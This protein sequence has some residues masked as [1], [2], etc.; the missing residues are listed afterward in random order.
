[1]RA[2]RRNWSQSRAVCAG[3]RAVGLAGTDPR[4]RHVAL[5]ELATESSTTYQQPDGTL[6]VE[7]FT[8]PVNFLAEGGLWTEISNDLVPADGPQRFVAENEANDFRARIPADGDTAPLRVDYEGSYVG[9]RLRELESAAPA[10]SGTTATF[11][12][13]AEADVVSYEVVSDGVKESITLDSAPSEAVAYTYDVTTSE[14]LE[15]RSSESGAIEFVDRDAAIEGADESD[16]DGVVLTIPAGQM[17]D[18]ASTL[19]NG[20]QGPAYSGEVEYNLR[21]VATDTPGDGVAQWTLTVTPDANWLSAPERQ[22]PVTVDPSI[23]TGPVG[24]CWIVDSAPADPHCGRENTHMRVGVSGDGSKYRSLLKF[25]LSGVPSNASIGD[26]AINLWM[27]GSQSTSTLG[28]AYVF[29]TPDQ[30]WGG[31]PTWNSSNQTGSWTGGDPDGDSYGTK[32]LNGTD[33]GYRTFSENVASLVQDWVQNVKPNRGLVFKQRSEDV[34]NVLWFRSSSRENRPGGTETDPDT[35][36][37]PYLSMTYTEPTDTADAGDRSFWS[38]AER[39]LTDQITAKVNVGN[40]NLL[41]SAKDFNVAGRAGQDMGLTRYYNS[42]S[43]T[44]NLAGMGPGWSSSLG[45]SVRLEYPNASNKDRVVFRGA[46]AYRAEFKLSNGIYEASGAGISA[47]LERTN[48]GN[49]FTLT[50]Y[51]RSKYV[52]DATSGQLKSMADPNGNKLTFSYGATAATNNVSR[53]MRVDDTRNRAAKFAYS[54]G[55]LTTATV[56][57]LAGSGDADDRAL[58]EWT[59]EYKVNNGQTVLASSRLSGVSSNIGSTVMSDDPNIGARTTYDYDGRQRLTRITDPRSNGNGGNVGASSDG[60]VTTF[61]YDGKR[62][63]ALTRQTDS[64]SI[65]D[66]TLGF[67]YIGDGFDDDVNPVV[68]DNTRAVCKA[69]N[70][71]PVDGIEDRDAASRTVVDGERTDV[72]DKTYYCVDSNDRVLRVTDANLNQRSQAYGPNS[73]VVAADMS[74]TGS[75]EQGTYSYDGK[76]NPTSSESPEGARSGA[77]YGDNTNTHSPTAVK[78]DETGGSSNRWQYEYD[79]KNN[80]IVAKAAANNDSSVNS[81]YHYCWTNDGQIYR[82]DPVTQAGN[83]VNSASPRRDTVV[84]GTPRTADDRCNVSA[85]GQGNDILFAYNAGGELT[86]VNRPA[87]GDE[88][89]TYDALSR[90][91]TKTDGRGVTTSYTYDGMGRQVRAVYRDNPAKSSPMSDQ[92][93]SWTFDLNGNLRYLEDANGRNEMIWDELNRKTSDQVPGNVSPNTTYAYDPA[94]NSLMVS[95]AGEPEPTRYAYDK[96]NRVSSVDDQRSGNAKITFAYDRKDKRTQ[97]IYPVPGSGNNIVQEARYDDDHQMKCIY[98]FR[99][100]GQ[101]GSNGQSEL[102]NAKDAC[103]QPTNSRLITYQGYD[104]IG[105]GNGGADVDTDPS[106]GV[107]TSTKWEITELGGAITTYGYDK[108]MRLTAAQTAKN[109]NTLRDFSYSYDRHSNLTREKATGSTPGLTNQTTWMAHNEG[110]EICASSTTAASA[111]NPNLTCSSGGNTVTSYARDAAGNLTTA[112]G[113]GTMSLD[114]LTLDYNLPGQ[115]KE[116]DPPGAIGALPQS[117]DGVMQD[118]RTQSGSTGM[119]YGYSGQVSAQDTGLG[120]DSQRA[121]RELFVRDP[122]GQLLA[123]IDYTGA[124]TGAVRYY[125][126]DDQASVLATM[127]S[128]APAAGTTPT[129]AKY[130]YEPYGETIRSWEDTAPG[131]STS[132]GTEQPA[133]APA[134]DVNP[135][136]FASGYYETSTGF[137]K[138]G[139]RYYMPQLGTWTQPDPKAPKL[140]SPMSVNLFHYAAQNPINVT[141]KTGRDYDFTLYPSDLNQIALTIGTIGA[142]ASIALAL[143][144]ITLPVSIAVAI[145]SAVGAFGFATLANYGCSVYVYVETFPYTPFGVSASTDIYGCSRE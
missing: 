108:I 112:T 23:V 18:S 127:S 139:T 69:D 38:Y 117:Y 51:D 95:V 15:P 22:Y 29:R 74:G 64:D 87:G 101:T 71:E 81:E 28:A 100:T 2:P 103:P 89:L 45:G 110:D 121:H 16:V 62:V 98:S 90:V 118:R 65:P 135:F 105:N 52:F 7:S 128:A 126:T 78:G 70:G 88:S 44:E 61:T 26:A 92:T 113:G 31:A 11:D 1:M 76:N 55:M 48:N 140:G 17:W 119:G 72:E 6:R 134:V 46:S 20:D 19:A 120:A 66:S 32:S 21:A 59:Y 10:V 41:V 25:D 131:T 114:G 84:N 33:T 125:L 137:I 83:A 141:D 132:I 111:G 9:M 34:K 12:E 86:G 130:L 102:G 14:N 63:S 42:A 133:N 80:L 40:G 106:T 107:R 82:I 143:G 97:T 24:D 122:S 50:Y 73:N 124:V 116:I 67:T 123:M 30:Q 136:R 54:N 3:G 4:V 93:L 91:A 39:Q 96:V 43:N 5:P 142:V 115:T 58:L 35:E 94:G 109:G 99:G 129:A 104:Y 85:G 27:N 138:F 145:V 36:K 68:G 53:L 37:R 79:D 57:D 56:F 75:G 144:G 47:V 8:E 49:E 13:V 60:G 77:T